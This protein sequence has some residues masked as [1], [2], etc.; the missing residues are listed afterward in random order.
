MEENN[1]FTPALS[2]PVD[3]SVLG[4]M[5]SAGDFADLAGKT[6][7]DAEDAIAAN[8]EP[9]R[10]PNAFDFSAPVAEETPAP[11][12]QPNVLDAAALGLIDEPH[13]AKT[14]ETP[15]EQ[16][17]AENVSA[18][19]S[20]LATEDDAAADAKDSGVNVAKDEKADKKAAKEA[21]K[22]AKKSDKS[23]K[24]PAGNSANG[25]PK[26]FTITLPMIILAVL[27]VLFAILAFVFW[28]ANES[29]N[30]KLSSANAQV[31]QLKNEIS[32]ATNSAGV[33]G[34]QFSGLQDKIAQMTQQQSTDQST[35]SSQKSQISDL[36]TKLTAAQQQSTNITNLGNQIT[37][38]LGN[39][40]MDNSIQKAG[41]TGQVTTGGKCSA[42]IVAAS[43]ANG[44]TTPAGISIKAD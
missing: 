17:A 38:L 6:V 39:C 14:D 33:N 36:N 24:T 21:E 13:F 12:A 15:V 42:T 23:A 25:A 16:A 9:A 43:S 20:T 22:L 34:G 19:I 32:Q 2:H 31:S 11:G 18:E 5:P 8:D 41:Q 29:S 37:G 44:Q 7:G 26:Q 1:P 10:N 35:I 27:V 40:T 4:D 3:S 28:S 30:K